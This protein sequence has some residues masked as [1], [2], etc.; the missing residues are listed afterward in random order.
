MEKNGLNQNFS[1]RQI[2]TLDYDDWH[3]FCCINGFELKS[4]GLYVP[5][6]YTAYVRNDTESLESD[7]FH[8]FFGHGLFCEKSLIGKELAERLKHYESRTKDE[9]ESRLS[10]IAS[11]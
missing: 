7:I 11:F 10:Y 3:R 4:T 8:E 9:E 5:K 6:T 2:K 1:C